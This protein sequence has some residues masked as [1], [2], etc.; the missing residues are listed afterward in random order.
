MASNQWTCNIKWDGSSY[1]NEAERMNYLYTYRGRQEYIREGGTGIEPIDTGYASIHVDNYD[2][3]YDPYNSSSPLYPN[4]TPGKFVQVMVDDGT[5]NQK[6]ISGIIQDIV[7]IE[8]T[9]NV[10]IIVEDGVRF[11]TESIASSQLYEGITIDEAINDILVTAGYPSEWGTLISTGTDIKDY[12]WASGD[13][14]VYAELMDLINSELGNAFIAA[15]GKFIFRSRHD[16][17]TSNGTITQEQMLK[18]I[19]IQMPWK[20]QRNIIKVSY[21]PRITQSS[22]V[23][24]THRETPYI[25]AWDSIEIWANFTYEGATVPVKNIVTPVSSTDFIANTAEDDSGTDLTSYISIIKEVFATSTKLTITNNASMGCYLTL[26]Q[27]RGEPIKAPDTSAVVKNGTGYDTNPK[28]LELDFPWLQNYNTANDFANYLKTYLSTPKEFITAVIQDRP[29]IQF[30]YDLFDIVTLDI[31][32]KNIYGDYRV[33]GIEHEFLSDNGKSVLTKF[34]CEPYSSVAGVWRF[35]TEFGV[36]SVF[37][38]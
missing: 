12:Y 16:I 23:V 21:H 19:I 7:P 26:M 33:G 28:T 9:K 6:V 35:P 38:W 36:S 2:E 17:E 27:L 14:R 22:Q 15:D 30:V 11:L 20:F 25:S 18:N 32:K 5:T 37:G 31:A 10:N 24:W 34:Y 29:T 4:C 3:R 8:N 13:K 1:T